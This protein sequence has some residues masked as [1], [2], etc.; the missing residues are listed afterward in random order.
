MPS[1]STRRATSPSTAASTT[2]SR[3]AASGSSSARSRRSSSHLPGVAQA[4]VVLRQDEGIDRLVAFLVLE[5]GVA[6]D[7]ATIRADLRDELP[8]LHDP[9]PFR[10]RR[11]PAAAVLR[12]GRPQVAARWPSS[13]SAT[14]RASRRSRANETEAALLVAAKRVFGNQAIPFERRLLHRSR[15]PL[16]ARRPLRLGGARGAGPRLDHAPGRLRQALPAGDGRRPHREDR[17]RRRRACRARPVLHAA[18]ADAP[19]PLRPRAGRG[20]AGHP[21]AQHDAVARHLR[22][23][24]AARRRRARLPRPDGGAARAS[25]SSST[26]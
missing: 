14:R 2:R 23:L 18:A 1:A 3:S 24:P 9:E 7:R 21:D 12:Q 20:A 10:D 26:R 22:H 5:A 6:L 17:R 19:L 15:R 16:A 13:P 11:G 8:A 25:M 4:A